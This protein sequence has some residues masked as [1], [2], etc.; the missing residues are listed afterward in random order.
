M[1][2]LIILP[3]LLSILCAGCSDADTAP[4]TD[5]TTPGDVAARSVEA[6]QQL[7]AAQT[8]QAV[9]V[10]EVARATAN[11][12]ATDRAR[13]AAATST[14]Q[15]FEL[16]QKQTVASATAEAVKLQ[17][18]MQANEYAATVS[19]RRVEATATA[20]A[21]EI[22]SALERQA[23]TATAAAID[24][25]Q[26]QAAE[27]SQRARQVSAIMG[28][29]APTLGILSIGALILLV[30]R[31]IDNWIMAAF[32]KWRLENRR[33]ALMATLI[34][35]RAGT[36]SFV[37]DPVAGYAPRL[38]AP[39]PMATNGLDF[40]RSELATAQQVETVKVTSAQGTVYIAKDAPVSDDAAEAGRKLTMKL[41]RDGIALVG[42]QSN[43]LP[44]CRDMGWP[45]ESWTKAVALLK[46]DYLTTKTGR[47][48]GTFCATT[49]YHSL[50]LLYAAIGER[51]IIPLLQA[52]ESKAA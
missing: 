5:G 52:A 45:S 38:L 50:A 13:S 43:R 48:G 34:E 37:G 6:R 20:A 36:V 23:A 39:G 30:F 18:T 41:L 35:S 22:Q 7:S 51:R 17:A 19:A 27:E 28:W 1:K 46:P 44:G 26:V 40:D 25:A 9:T 14:A 10:R 16:S 3:L 42:G 33:L 24:R 29:V 49:Q 15:A 8:A 11:S 47:A 4:A 32:E 31:L 2:A 12:V 21:G